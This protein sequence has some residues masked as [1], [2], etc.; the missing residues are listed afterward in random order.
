MLAKQHECVR[1]RKEMRQTHR[2]RKYCSAL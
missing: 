2:R 1:E